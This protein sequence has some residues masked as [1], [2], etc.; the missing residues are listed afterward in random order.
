MPGTVLGTVNAMVN[1]ILSL[2]A[3]DLKSRGV[4]AVVAQW[5]NDLACLCGSASSI[6]GPLQCVKDPVLLQLLH[7]LQLCLRFCSWPGN[8]NKQTNTSR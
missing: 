5:V 4:V 8:L 7:R 3:K 2:L 1:K 6:P